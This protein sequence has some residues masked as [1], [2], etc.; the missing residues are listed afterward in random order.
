MHIHFGAKTYGKVK[1][2]IGNVDRHAL[3]DGL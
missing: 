2:I 3:L 1:K